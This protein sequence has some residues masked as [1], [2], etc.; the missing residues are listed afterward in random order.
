MM[1]ATEIRKDARNHL[2]NK[3]GKG[4]LIILCYFLIEFAINL[5]SSLTEEIAIINLLISIA[6]LVISIPLSYGLIISFMKL[7]RDE[8][9]K[10]FDF[11]ILG[12]S[13]FSK[14]WKVA[15]SMFVRLIVPFV[16]T[17]ISMIILIVGISLIV[18]SG[19]NSIINHSLSSQ[20]S[21]NKN[22][23]LE[24][25]RLELIKAQTNYAENPTDE[26]NKSLIEARSKVNELN[27]SNSSSIMSNSNTRNMFSSGIVT[28]M[29][30]F[31]L[32]VFSSIYSYVKQLHYVLSYNIAY[33]EPD[34]TSKEIV[35]KSKDL[36]TGNRK[37]YFVLTLSFIGWSLLAVLTFGI[38]YLW[39]LPYIQVS[40]ICFYDNL[41]N[42]VEDYKK[43]DKEDSIEA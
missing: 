22:S 15:F 31:I 36:M 11:L 6:T 32:L 40:N 25:A 4:A 1:T 34:L 35:L 29:L 41:K 10:A 3:W 2:T 26:N 20:E 30:G 43:D 14:A 19:S 13:S 27:S 38:G 21:I 23:E 8:E 5:L 33:D 24:N 42:K 12:F 28:T 39:L 7:K 37:N 16:L 17:I 18:A 9:V